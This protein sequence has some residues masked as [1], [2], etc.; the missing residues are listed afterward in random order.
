M[1]W[2]MGAGFRREGTYVYLWLLCADA[3]GGIAPVPLLFTG[4]READMARASLKVTQGHRGSI[5]SG[6][7]PV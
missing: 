3:S 6:S 4:I 2:E 7:D 1:G 5:S